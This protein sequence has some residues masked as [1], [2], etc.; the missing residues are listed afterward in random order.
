MVYHPWSDFGLIRRYLLFIGLV[1][2][3][4]YMYAAMLVVI[5]QDG[6]TLLM[7]ASVYGHVECVKVLLDRDAQPDVQDKVSAVPEQANVS[8]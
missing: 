4:M 7:C 2:I 6:R 5:L 1:E 3:Y 8:C